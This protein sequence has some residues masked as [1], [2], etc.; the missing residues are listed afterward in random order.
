MEKVGPELVAHWNIF[1]DGLS[2]SP[3]TFYQYL[4]S[5]IESHNLKDVKIDI[6]TFREKSVFSA[7]RLYLRIRRGPLTYYVCA[8]PYGE[9]FFFSSWFFQHH[10]FI[11]K[12]L[13]SIPLIGNALDNLLFPLTFHV[14]DSTNMFNLIIQESVKQTV[15][16]IAK[17]GG[18]RE[19][20]EAEAK[21]V[22][23]DYFKR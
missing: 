17:Q 22:V 2:F 6:T 5:V 15:N 9:G 7:K 16:Y 3:Q 4:K 8:A 19:L 18:S 1:Y 23:R 20:S 10:P 12:F 13:R 14:V 11:R 21:P